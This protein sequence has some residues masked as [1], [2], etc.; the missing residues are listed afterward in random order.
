MFDGDQLLTRIE[1]GL[2]SAV[3]LVHE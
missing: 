2:L 3:R 1:D